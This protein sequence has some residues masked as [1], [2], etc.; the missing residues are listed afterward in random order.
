MQILLSGGTGF[1]AQRAAKALPRV[2]VE[3]IVLDTS[4]AGPHGSGLTGPAAGESV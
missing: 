1:D 4:E 3:P 2:G